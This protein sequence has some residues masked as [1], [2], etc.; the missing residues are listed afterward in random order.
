MSNRKSND[1]IV[2]LFSQSHKFIIMG[3]FQL[4]TYNELTRILLNVSRKSDTKNF[5]IWE[6]LIKLTS[7]VNIIFIYNIENLIILIY[8]YTLKMSQ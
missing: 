4:P 7:N 8:N 2:V 1:E 6:F 3:K 5:Y